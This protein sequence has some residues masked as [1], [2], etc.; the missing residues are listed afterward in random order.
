[1]RKRK[2]SK[3]ILAAAL[4]A[5]MLAGCA[6]SKDASDTVQGSSAAQEAAPDEKQADSGEQITIQYWHRGLP[7]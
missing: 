7:R 4:S 5:V 2:Y 3:R 6:G 1:M